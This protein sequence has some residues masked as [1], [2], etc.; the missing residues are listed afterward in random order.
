VT[1][2]QLVGI[3]TRISWQPNVSSAH[4][5]FLVRKPEKLNVNHAHLV[6]FRKIQD[7]LNV[8]SVNLAKK[9]RQIHKLLSAARANLVFLHPLLRRSTI[10]TK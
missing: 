8:M 9:Q 1:F 6:G 10:T 2:A 3:P 5:D 4:L 7:N